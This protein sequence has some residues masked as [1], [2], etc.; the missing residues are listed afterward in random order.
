MSPTHL[1]YGIYAPSGEAIDPT[2]C[3]AA[4]RPPA[5]R[6]ARAL[7]LRAPARLLSEL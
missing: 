1:H 2:P 4:R 7:R 5:G 3:C 6:R